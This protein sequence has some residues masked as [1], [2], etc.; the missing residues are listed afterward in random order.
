GLLHGEIELALADPAEQSMREMK[1]DRNPG[2]PDDDRRAPADEISN[3][4]AWESNRS[5]NAEVSR[6]CNRSS[7]RPSS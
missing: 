7:A 4:S 1:C 3:G 6:A 5:L 2:E